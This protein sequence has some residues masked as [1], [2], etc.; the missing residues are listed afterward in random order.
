MESLAENKSLNLKSSSRFLV[1]CAYISVY[2]I[3]RIA[4]LQSIS[5]I[6][7]IITFRQHAYLYDHFRI[8]ESFSWPGFRPGCRDTAGFPRSYDWR[9]LLR[10]NSLPRSQWT[11]CQGQ[12]DPLLRKFP[13]S[14][15]CLFILLFFVRL[16]KQMSWMRESNT[17]F[18]AVLSLTTERK[19]KIP[20]VDVTRLRP[21]SLLA[22]SLRPFPPPCK[23][24][25]PMG[26]LGLLDASELKG[27]SIYCG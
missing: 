25:G 17:F 5:S 26:F 3:I 6:P 7:F 19:Q 15:P 9:N 16:V 13:V 4:F 12:A 14:V 23:T 22:A 1:R 24:A 27:I 8:A 21:L 2:Q 10:P 20:R 18:S 11:M